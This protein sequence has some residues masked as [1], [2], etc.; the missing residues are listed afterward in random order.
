[1]QFFNQTVLLKWSISDTTNRF[2]DV[3]RQWH[4]SVGLKHFS[5]CNFSPGLTTS[6]L[7]GRWRESKFAKITRSHRL[8]S[9]TTSSRVG[10]H[11]KLLSPT[12]FSGVQPYMRSE[13]SFLLSVSV[14]QQYDCFFSPLMNLY[15]VHLLPLS[16]LNI[17][18]N[19]FDKFWN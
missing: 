9:E 17:C 19:L 1:M 18:M 12:C 2:D 6:T 13:L 11:V 5:C 4:F 10:A 15:Q 16:I 14:T 7:R 3:R 8:V